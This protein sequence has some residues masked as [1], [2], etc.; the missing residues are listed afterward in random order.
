YHAQ[1]AEWA[2]ALEHADHAIAGGDPTA[3]TRQIRV[4]ALLGLGRFEDARRALDAM[5]QGHPATPA[6][7]ALAGQYL[8]AT[9]KPLDAV[10]R[11]SRAE[12]AFPGNADLAYA[13]GLAAAAAQQPARAVTEFRHAVDL[14]PTRYAAW[15]QLAISSYLAGDVDGSRRAIER[16]SALPAA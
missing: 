13:A 15:L 1:R 14:E 3:E 8:V 12:R 6:L 10:D 4:V 7:E 2:A 16:A 11:L 5:R 9:G